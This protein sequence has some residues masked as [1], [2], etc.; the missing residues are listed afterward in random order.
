MYDLIIDTETA[1]IASNVSINQ[2]AQNSLV[3][4]I[5]GVVRD[6]STGDIIK[7]FSFVIA[8]TFYNNN[9]MESAYYK[10]KIPT[11]KEEIQGGN[12]KV[13]TFKEAR[14]Y[15][16]KLVNFYNIRAVWAY[17]V[18]FDITSLNTTIK[19]Y[20]N[21]YV[22]HFLP[23]G[24]K[25][26]DIWARCT[27]IT[28]TKKY[29]SWCFNNGFVTEKGNPQ[30]SAEIVYRYLIQNNNFVESHTALEDA[31]I[32]AFILTCAQRCKKKARKGWGMG[33]LPAQQIAKTF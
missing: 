20:S 10:E 33:Y 2:L 6:T 27:N 25:V 16:K 21:G 18:R 17:N 31:K 24:L 29:V 13:I 30:T 3:Y 26:K 15:I 23:Y 32:E 14:D 8:E 9:I 7:E 19:R 5:G 11:Y 12:R 1:P 22:K 28:G 4:D